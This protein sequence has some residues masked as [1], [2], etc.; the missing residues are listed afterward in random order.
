MTI[1]IDAL[2]AVLAKATP[3]KWQRQF[4]DFEDGGIA[5]VAHIVEKGVVLETPTNGMVCWA[6]MLPVER[7]QYD[8]D[9]AS[10]NSAAIVA[11]HNA[12]PAL[13]A[14]HRRMA[15]RIAELEGALSRQSDNM[16]F[17]LNHMPVPGQWYH[18]FTEEL[19]F[20]RAV[21]CNAND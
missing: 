21:L 15:A 16:A 2:E 5:V 7:D 13:I 10:A 6:N 11:L 3:G 19:E 9:R 18:K 17:V 1:D 8:D 14:E 20:D 4:T 12:A